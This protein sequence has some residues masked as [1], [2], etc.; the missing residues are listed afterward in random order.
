MA[1]NQNS[2]QYQST[3]K[4]KNL[5]N[6]AIMEIRAG[7]GGDEAALFAAQLFNMYKRYA[8]NH[9][10]AVDVVDSCQPSIGGSKSVVFEL[11]GPEAFPK[12]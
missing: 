5:N 3:P 1:Y 12:M 8:L 2:Y 4:P 7:A 10:W 6:E 11:Q 9:G